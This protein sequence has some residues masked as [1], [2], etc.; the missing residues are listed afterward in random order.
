[1]PAINAIRT[2]FLFVVTA[3][4]AQIA[5]AQQLPNSAKLTEAEHV[6]FFESKVRPLLIKHCLECHSAETEASGGLMLD[7]RPN[8]ERGGDSGA[9][10][11]PEDPAEGTLMRAVLY[12]DPDLQMPP[13]GKLPDAAIEALRTWIAMGAADPRSEV[14]VKPSKTQALAVADAQRH[15]AYRASERPKLPE[16]PLGSEVSASA[17]A[18]PLDRFI[19]AKL[20]TASI[21]PTPAVNRAQWLRRLT[22]DLHGL[23]PDPKLLAAFEQDERPDA[24]ARM[25]EQ[26]LSSPRFGETFARHWMD[27]ARYAESITLRG[28]VLP[29]AWRY[30]DYLIEA[31]NDD[32]RF[33]QMI[34][35]Q[36]AGDLLHSDD[37]NERTRQLVA[38]SFL[39][40]GNTNLEEQDK[41]QLEMDFIDE[42]LEVLGRAFLGQ[43]IGCAR[44]HDH[45]FDPIP[46]RD[47]YALA[48][49]FRNTTALEH[50]NVSKW[51]EAP[52]PMEPEQAAKFE[53][54]SAEI[55]QLTQAIASLKKKKNVV[56]DSEKSID[57]KQLDGIVVD[58]TDAKLIGTWIDGTSVPGYV[59]G[60]YLHDGNDSQ[61]EKSATFEPPQLMPGQY[62]VR[63][64]YTASQNRATNAKVVVFSADGEHSRR[65][66]QK[67]AP[68][69]GIWTTLGTYRFEKD[70]Q[71]FV[72]VSNSEAD[73]HVVIDAIQFLPVGFEIAKSARTNDAAITDAASKSSSAQSVEVDVKAP[74]DRAAATKR[75]NRE[76]NARRLAASD[77]VS[78]EASATEADN[79]AQVKAMEKELTKLQRRLSARPS[80]MTV[81]EK[82]PA[83][84][85]P[86]AIRGNVHSSGE[87]VPRGFL[88][89]LD[90][91]ANSQATFDEHSSGR[92]PLARW[93]SDPRNPLTARVYANRVWSWLIGQ[94]L[95]TTTNNFGTTGASP[96]HPELLDWLAD[97]LIRSGWSTKHLVR[98]IV[99]SDVYRRGV[100]EA[101]SD[102]QRADPNNEL[103]WRANLRRVS[104]EA[105]RDAML[106]ASGELDGA[107]GGSLLKPDVKED[108]NY[109]H[110]STRRSLYHP[111]LRNALPELFEA[112]DFA[113]TSV[114]IGER[115]RS[116]VAPQALIML[117]HP[118]VVARAEA[119]A[120]RIER[121]LS[122]PEAAIEHL[123]KIC[124][125]RSATELEMKAC[126]EFLS[127]ET[128]SEANTSDP[129]QPEVKQPE[130]KRLDTK[131]L[132]ALVQALFGSLDFRYLE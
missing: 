48:G 73:G 70:G 112:F 119:T 113:D 19:D 7:S 104:I 64:S 120:Q 63:I 41:T 16:V 118:W 76:T 45:K 26:L 36:V 23:S 30:R 122:S 60:R 96:T 83:K 47:Y 107:V 57:I 94:G 108:Y 67:A 78:K 87:V 89:A 44:C 9:A 38:T 130:T 128:P 124:L 62:R 114:S 66:D 79:A 88:T 86:V 111:V 126:L 20:Q 14:S 106:T 32:R 129:K 35:E 13:D 109:A 25:V 49:I 91:G 5:Y 40:L 84:D 131:R 110:Q 125:G 98:C 54:L 65:I 17:S 3:C 10:I 33:D 56:A 39:A 117:N 22:F 24:E 50:S 69:D 80:F 82:T 116:T 4:C 71:A 53:A 42:Q 8:W 21:A 29:E 68:E 59:A 90:V 103:L 121:E 52:L 77:L 37:R 81:R 93:L 102:A 28:F 2:A 18:S 105:L 34:V 58:D 115:A 46:T 101:T 100:Q 51:V 72:I 75:T 95:V 99:L 61:G 55:S 123:H 12:D 6:D 127:L 74:L 15:W 92:L 11:V 97:E 31:F 85:I 132:A 1:M 43:T 27:V